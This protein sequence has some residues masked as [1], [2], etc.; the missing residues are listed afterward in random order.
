MADM[1]GKRILVTGGAKRI[2][3]AIALAAA[4]EGA[5]VAITYM[6]SADAA[7][8]TVVELQALDVKAFA[9]H[10]DVRDPQSVR[11]V[12]AQAVEK[13]GGLDVLINNAGRFE[14]ARFEEITVEQWDDVF[15]TDTRG[16][17]LMS[18]CALPALRNSGG[19]IIHI[20]SLGG[21]RPWADHA[22]YCAAKAALHMLTQVM[23]K[24]LAPE[25]SV[26]CVA[27]GMIAMGESTPSGERERF[28]E[29]T[30]M[31]VTGRAEHRPAAVT[32][33]A[34]APRWITGHIPAVHRG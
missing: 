13:L 1:K 31:K 17:F 16:P 8:R 22:H 2:G 4:H 9:I 21:I 18:Q 30:P 23:A 27:P 24:A 7:Q 32:F 20:G 34:T 14:N 28:A 33:L 5:D 10:C 3:R 29:K 12:C 19:R 6:E 26:N 25:I 15:Q 11:Q